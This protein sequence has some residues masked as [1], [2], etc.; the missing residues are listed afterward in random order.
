MPLLAKDLFPES[1]P[2]PEDESQP[3]LPLAKQVA[4]EIANSRRRQQ[5]TARL[6]IWR[7]S[8]SC[9]RRWSIT[10]SAIKGR[11]YTRSSSSTTIF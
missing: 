3:S 4:G 5:Q 11:R 2:F 8:R 10:S 7:R 1:P 9:L 6:P